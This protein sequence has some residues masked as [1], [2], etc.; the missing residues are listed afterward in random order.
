MKS[1]RQENWD[2]CT[3]LDDGGNELDQETWDLQQRREKV[4]Q[5]VDD[6]PLDVRSVV[7]LGM[8]PYQFREPRCSKKKG[9]H[10]EHT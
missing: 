7:I 10:P 5:E 6:Q 3:D 4:V 1:L 9:S 8:Y 2:A